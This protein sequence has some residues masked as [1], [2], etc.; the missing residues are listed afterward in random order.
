MNRNAHILKTLPTWLASKRFEEIII[1]DYGSLEPLEHTLAAAGL[2]DHAR[3]RIIR[4]E[5]EQWCLAE[6]FNIGLLQAAAPF[7]LKLDAD[8]LIRGQAEL[9]L[10]LSAQQFRTGNWR[11]F[12]NN[13]LNGV[14]LVPTQAIRKTGGYNEQIRCYGWD[15]CDFYERLSEL[16]LIKTDLFEHEFH[17]LDHS[18]DE[19]VAHSDTVA[20]SNDIN[21]LI[22]GNGVLNNLLPK[23]TDKGKRQFAFQ[24]LDENA[25]QL[26]TSVR[27]VAYKIS[28]I[29]DNYIY[30]EDS[31]YSYEAMLKDI[32]SQISREA[33][34]RLAPPSSKKS[35]IILMVS[36]YEDRAETRRR[37][38]IRCLR[39]NSQIFDKI[40]VL[41]EQ[42][43][44][45][46]D[47][48][49]SSVA[50]ELKRLSVMSRCEKHVADIEKII[51]NERPAYRDFFKLS[52]MRSAE[53]QKPWFVIANSDIAF[54][55]SIRRIN[56]LGDSSDAIICLSRW[57]KCS[58]PAQKQPEDCYLDH[59]G[60]KWALIES[61][62][63]SGHIPNYLSAD[64]WIYSELPDDW[65]DYTYR[66]GTYF[67]D[68]F[69]ANRAFQSGRTV[70]NPCRSIRCFHHHD[71]ENNSSAHKFEDKSNIE[72]LYNEERERLGGEDP[73]AGVQWTTLETCNIPYFKP[74]PYRW[75]PKGGLCL[76]LGYVVNVPSILLM[77][78]AGLKATEDTGMDLFVHIASDESYSTQTAIVLEFAEYL[79]NPR[80]F[81]DLG[82]GVFDPSTPASH[83][84]L[85]LR[86]S[87]PLCYGDWGHIAESIIKHIEL[88]P[89]AHHS[90]RTHLELL[91]L[92]TLDELYAVAFLSARH[93]DVLQPYLSEAQY[94]AQIALS[95]NTESPTLEPRFSLVTSL[96]RAKKYLPRLLEN[97]EAV[98]SLGPCELVIVDVNPDETDQE[99]IETFISHSEY[100]HTIQYIHLKEDPGIYGCWMKAIGMSKSCFVSNFNADDRR[101]AVHPHLLAKYLRENPGVDACFTAI[102]PTNVDNLSWYEHNEEVSWFH[103]Y[104][105]GRRFSPSDF[106]TERDGVYCS[107][108]IAHCMPMWR[109]SLH[110]EC[111]SF[112]EDKYGT[113]A[114]WA[115]WLECMKTGKVLAMASADPLGLYFINPVSHN[116]RHDR[117]GTLENSIIYDFYG[118]R[119]FKFVQQ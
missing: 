97:Y 16:S 114:D 100:G 96:Y 65:E 17:S 41:Y 40:I 92:L 70:I 51:I 85:A 112:R 95:N 22:Q 18:D 93:P 113:S 105:K 28:D 49:D 13:V 62:A 91:H 68:S 14:V 7:T 107:Q 86:G 119:Q 80:L 1:V 23:W 50:N 77:I 111:G 15:D 25:K 94:T 73:V 43:A 10:R 69:F 4:T 117:L 75:N 102:R 104:E 39:I 46:G 87:A 78:E 53:D 89:N 84:H 30:S 63:D 90:D 99:T 29:Q 115:F 57:D 106:L 116:R 64:A 19:R 59:D 82:Q 9:S 118:I 110:D 58:E 48:L 11:T 61:S 74:K 21:R 55:S 52:S 33:A 108:N 32:V 27:D 81:L 83:R 20:K 103:W 76:N 47:E 45:S 101:S 38:M 88:D 31:A 72:Q 2:L 34:P 71:E 8:T 3:V 36:L 79:R 26:L 44:S 66:I 109:K 12:E 56:E 98:A 24:T 6:A 60:V 67:C 5:A 37:E 35:P 42:P 54:D